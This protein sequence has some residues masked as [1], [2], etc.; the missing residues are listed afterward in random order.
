MQIEIKP[1]DIPSIIVLEKD[2]LFQ[3]Y[4]YKLCYQ[5]LVPHEQL[6]L[7]STSL[8]PTHVNMVHFT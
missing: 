7:L 1:R 6:R 4:V 8:T 5:M 3:P 2:R